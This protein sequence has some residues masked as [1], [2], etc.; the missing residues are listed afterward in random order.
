MDANILNPY[1]LPW[2]RE[3]VYTNSIKR[4]L[5]LF[6]RLTG[7]NCFKKGNQYGAGTGQLLPLCLTYLGAR[8]LVKGSA[9]R[10]DKL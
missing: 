7:G 4:V 1:S 8:V 10:G 3:G 9:I 2:V 5:K 6:L